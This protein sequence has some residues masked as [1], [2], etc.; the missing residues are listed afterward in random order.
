MIFGAVAVV[1]GI[2]SVRWQA[3]RLRPD[4]A[5]A[6]RLETLMWAIYLALAALI[7]IGFALRE[8]GEGWMKVELLGLLGYTTLG[9]LG[10]RGRGWL[11]ALGWALHAAWDMVVHAGVPDLFVPVWYRW[12]CLVF[13]FGAAGPIVW[14]ETSISIVFGFRF[15]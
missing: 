3:A 6:H 5:Q 7:Y 8:A 2:V 9:W 1:L 13:D 4:P 12:A 14:E 15:H 11:L 10:T